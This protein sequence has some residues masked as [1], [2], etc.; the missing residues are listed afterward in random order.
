[1]KRLAI[2]LGLAISSILV[3]P[4]AYADA[5]CKRS[6]AH[7]NDVA[8]YVCRDRNLGYQEFIGG[9]DFG[10]AAAIALDKATDAGYDVDSCHRRQ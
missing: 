8:I 2:V 7:C 5:L 6:Y 10:K 9:S 1:M 3:A 4:T